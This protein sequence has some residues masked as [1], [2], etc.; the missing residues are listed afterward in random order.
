MSVG[1]GLGDVC[2][3]GP[4]YWRPI[5]N[6]PPIERAPSTFTLL[7]GLVQLV[8]PPRLTVILKLK[9]LNSVGLK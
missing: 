5:H 8:Y 4:L 1:G 7:I 2:W 3:R 9:Y 6:W